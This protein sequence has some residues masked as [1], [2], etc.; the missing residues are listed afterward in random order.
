MAEPAPAPAATGVEAAQV[1]DATEVL[2]PDEDDIN[3]ICQVCGRQ[4][5]R[6]C[7]I[8]RWT[9]VRRR[10]LRLRDDEDIVEFRRG[11]AADDA[12][13]ASESEMPCRSGESSSCSL[14]GVNSQVL[15]DAERINLR[16][17][18]AASE[19]P[20]PPLRRPLPLP[21]AVGCAVELWADDPAHAVGTV[22]KIAEVS[23]AASLD[24]MDKTTALGSSLV[25]WGQD[26]GQGLVDAVG[27]LQDDATRCVN[28]PPGG[29]DVRGGNPL[30]ASLRCRG[31][32]I[33]K[34][35]VLGGQEQQDQQFPSVGTVEVPES[36]A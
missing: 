35:P 11:C 7:G 30:V 14:D 6:C 18:L 23:R 17:C 8:E 27:K 31:G 1:A 16:G 15:T 2:V 21:L 13:G 12:S 32:A 9:A 29:R 25:R 28:A 3:S 20:F 4:G 5:H 26:F 34:E 19:P 33:K 24:I 36:T 22:A 10:W